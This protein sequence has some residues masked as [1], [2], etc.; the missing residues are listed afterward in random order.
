MIRL[1]LLHKVRCMETCL[2]SPKFLSTK[3]VEEKSKLT[4]SK[5][6][7]KW[8]TTLLGSPLI[9]RAKKVRFKWNIIFYIIDDGINIDNW[10]FEGLVEAVN[11]FKNIEDSQVVASDALEIKPAE[12]TKVISHEDDFVDLKDTDMN[13]YSTINFAD[14]P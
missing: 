2:V 14:C 9:W 10:T 8:D 7:L 3:L 13:I 5:I 1:T 12:V 4:L 11:Q 6:L